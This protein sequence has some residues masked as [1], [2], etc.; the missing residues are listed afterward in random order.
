MRRA[1][2]YPC[3]GPSASS[4]FRTIKS[5]V[6][7]NRSGRRSIIGGVAPLACAKECN[8]HSSGMSK[9][10]NLDGGR[11]I[12]THHRGHDMQWLITLVA[13]FAL[14]QAAPSTQAE[15]LQEA[16]RKGDAA[17]VKK[18]LDDGVDVNTKFRY[19]ATAL[20]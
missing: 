20:F 14:A 12:G 17:A 11:T 19:G 15:Q 18:L 5:S 2:P 8:T 9:G 7:C 1:I 4:V 6:P 16:A 13:I 10:E 3:S